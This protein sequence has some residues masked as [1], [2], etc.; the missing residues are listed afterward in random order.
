[1]MVTAVDGTDNVPA[2]S[3]DPYVSMFRLHSGL[4]P[5]AARAQ[6]TAT[7]QLQRGYGYRY[8]PVFRQGVSESVPGRCERDMAMMEPHDRR[9]LQCSASLVAASAVGDCDGGR[10]ADGGVR[11]PRV[12]RQRSDIDDSASDPE[13]RSPAHDDCNGGA[14]GSAPGSADVVRIESPPIT[15]TVQVHQMLSESLRDEDEDEDEQGVVG[16]VNFTLEV[17]DQ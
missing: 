13:S 5:K 6:L 14:P 17:G 9:W 16:G 12:T 11:A 7:K 3:T 10:T 8:E 4:L 15:A 2:F 1:M